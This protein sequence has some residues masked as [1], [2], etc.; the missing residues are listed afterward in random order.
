ML[1]PPRRPKMCSLKELRPW[2][3]FLKPRLW[4]AEA[5]F[6]VNRPTAPAAMSVKIERFMV[7]SF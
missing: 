1:K 3:R 7:H 4:S 6:V 2:D 5:S